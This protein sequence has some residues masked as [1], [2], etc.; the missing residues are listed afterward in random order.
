MKR[1]TFTIMLC[2]TII[3]SGCSEQDKKWKEASALN[4][5]YAYQ[6]YDSLFPDSQ[7]HEEILIKSDILRKSFGAKCLVVIRNWNKD[8]RDGNINYLGSVNHQVQGWYDIMTPM[9]PTI[10]LWREL[11]LLG[12]VI[13]KED[14][15]KNNIKTNIIYLEK[16]GYE[17]HYIPVEK[18]LTMTDE[19]I[20]NLYYIDFNNQTEKGEN[21]DS[22]YIV[23]VNGDKW[24]EKGIIN[25]N[26]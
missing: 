26:K 10:Y 20:A 21:P 2:C 7:H 4:T 11:P 24:I 8:P 1:I 18:M 6:T 25:N 5:I 23:H 13:F 19:E 15:D 3:I 22:G 17:G 14:R 16:S 12:D 9:R